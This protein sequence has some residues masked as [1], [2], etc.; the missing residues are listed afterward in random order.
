HLAA[1]TS[2]SAASLIRVLANAGNDRVA[3]SESFADQLF[4]DL[5]AGNDVLNASGALAFANQIQL[6]GN[7]GKDKLNGNAALSAAG[8]AAASLFGFES[9]L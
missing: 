7:V 1:D 5:G 9:I 2:G 3:I 4:A 8:N 6:N